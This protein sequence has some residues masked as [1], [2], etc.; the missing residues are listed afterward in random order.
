MGKILGLLYA[1]F[2]ITHYFSFDVGFANLN[3]VVRSIR[4]VGVNG[5]LMPPGGRQWRTLLTAIVQKILQ[6]LLLH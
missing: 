3:I 1:P 5:G 2:D 4:Q 6:K